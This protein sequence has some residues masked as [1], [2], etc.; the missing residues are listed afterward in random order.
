ML[1]KVKNAIKKIPTKLREFATDIH[2]CY[3][4]RKK[5]RYFKYTRFER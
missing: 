5:N 1:T 2:F 4:R 3:V